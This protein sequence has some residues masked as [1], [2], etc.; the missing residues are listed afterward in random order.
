VVDHPHSQSH[1]LAHL[2]TPSASIPVGL[3]L[4][5]RD[6]EALAETVRR[7]ASA[8]VGLVDLNF[9]CPAKGALRGCAG[10]AL[11]DH[12]QLMERLIRR[13]V[14]AAGRIC[15]TAKIRAGIESAG[16]LEDL[17]RAVEGGGASMLTVH[18]RT[19]K[20]GFGHPVDWSRIRRAKQ[21]VGIPVCG[22]GGVRDHADLERM[23]RETGCD[24]VMVGHAALA[25]P[26][27]FS[28]SV[29]SAGEAMG[30]LRDYAQALRLRGFSPRALTG[31]VKQLLQHWSCD[32]LGPADREAWLHE[33]D[34]ARLL[35]QLD[36]RLKQTTSS[37][38]RSPAGHRPRRAPTQKS[39]G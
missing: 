7:A 22:N 24:L 33:K 2:G 13:C 28:G 38:T 19:R 26:W 37:S 11:L 20:E 17:A 27:V 15:V 35:A 30:F 16:C 12:P 6:P 18:A 10:S 31:R 1:L 34:P 23:R 3:Q 4:M 39:G 32:G 25:N 9:G 5:G 8:G 14:E 36:A 21:A 29:A